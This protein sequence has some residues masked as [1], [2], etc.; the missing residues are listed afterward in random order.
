MKKMS[1]KRKLIVLSAAIMLLSVSVFSIQ[2]IA[3]FRA[4]DKKMATA[5]ITS[6]KISFDRTSETVPAAYAAET[7]LQYH[8]G[9]WLAGDVFTA[10]FHV[11]VDSGISYIPAPQ[12]DLIG[13]GNVNYNDSFEGTFT[14]EEVGSTGKAVYPWSSEQTC[15]LAVSSTVKKVKVTYALKVSAGKSLPAETPLAPVF[16]CALIQADN[17]AAGFEASCRRIA[18]TGDNTQTGFTDMIQKTEVYD[19]AVKTA[20]AKMFIDTFG[21]NAYAN[22]TYV[23]KKLDFSVTPDDADAANAATTV[24]IYKMD[25]GNS[26]VKSAEGGY[27]KAPDLTGAGALINTKT[28]YSLRFWAREGMECTVVVD[29]SNEE[30]GHRL[31]RYNIRWP[32]GGSLTCTKQELDISGNDWN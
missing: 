1:R 28:D 22:G 24:H 3:K 19:G 2:A 25:N 7:N 26:V 10:E 15:G 21:P 5:V 17:Q 23:Q 18:D 11:N 13:S 12:L 4:A 30:A 16:S 20:P 6:S 31:I 27:D 9:D 29:A 32:S 8:F 14:V